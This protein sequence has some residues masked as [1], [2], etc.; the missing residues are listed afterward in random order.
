VHWASGIPHALTRAEEFTHN[1][2][3]IR[4]AGSRIRILIFSLCP[5]LRG[6]ANRN[7]RA[8]LLENPIRKDDL[9]RDAMVRRARCALT[10]YVERH[11]APVA[12]M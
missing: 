6:E 7:A 3:A 10:D 11:M 12:H 2:G 8:R 4:A 5:F 1:P 9:L